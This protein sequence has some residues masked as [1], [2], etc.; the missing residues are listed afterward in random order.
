VGGAEVKE[1]QKTRAEKSRKGE[2]QG[3]KKDRGTSQ[4]RRAIK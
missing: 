2:Q 1:E 3:E 4:S